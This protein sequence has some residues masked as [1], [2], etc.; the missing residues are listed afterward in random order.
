MIQDRNAVVQPYAFLIS[1]E[2]QDVSLI[3][4]VVNA[5][6]DSVRFMEGAGVVEVESLGKLDVYE[7]PAGGD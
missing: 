6:S 5:I 4:D 2:L 1:V 3:P 7:D